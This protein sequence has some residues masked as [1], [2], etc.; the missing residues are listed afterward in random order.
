MA[1]DIIINGRTYQSVPNVLI[2][3]ADGGGSTAN[4][5]DTDVASDAA[6]AA[7]IRSSKKAFVNGNEVVGTMPNAVESHEAR[8]NGVATAANYIHDSQSGS[9]SNLTVRATAHRSVTTGGYIQATDPDTSPLLA[10]TNKY[11]WINYPTITCA[12]IGTSISQYSLPSGTLTPYVI[13]P[14]ITGAATD[15][16]VKNGVTYYNTSLKAQRTGTGIMPNLV[17]NDS[18][19]VLSIS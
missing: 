6:G 11:L 12:D 3:I 18:T 13:L 2:P 17:Y 14:A 7:D 16:D 10:T 19:H 1:K 8:L 5:V 4:F 15:A 9:Y